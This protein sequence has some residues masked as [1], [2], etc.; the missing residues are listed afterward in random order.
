MRSSDAPVCQEF[1]RSVASLGPSNGPMSCDS[2][3][4]SSAAASRPEWTNIERKTLLALTRR[5]EKLFEESLGHD[6]AWVESDEFAQLATSRIESGALT[7]STVHV[8][9]A[10]GDEYLRPSPAIVIRYQRYGCGVTF[11]GLGYVWGNHG[12]GSEVIFFRAAQDDLKQLQVLQGTD[13][14]KDIFLFNGQAYF[15]GEPTRGK[16]DPPQLAVDEIANDIYLIRACRLIY[17]DKPR[18]SAKQK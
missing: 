6:G 13:T 3:F 9:L 5:L 8:L 17:W 16:K 10:T 18:S 12:V 1:E 2:P 7:I 4:Y 14:P 15:D 11:P